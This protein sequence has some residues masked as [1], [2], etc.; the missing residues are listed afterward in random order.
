MAN[1]D[2]KN[3]YPGEF[4]NALSCAQDGI[5]DADAWNTT[6][7]GRCDGESPSSGPSTRPTNSP[8]AE[9]V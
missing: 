3:V 2:P 6:M 9:T 5:L 1:G 4:L 8:P 7:K